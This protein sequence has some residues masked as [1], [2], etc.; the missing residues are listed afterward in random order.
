MLL[1]WGSHFSNS[2]QYSSLAQHTDA[3]IVG[4]SDRPQIHVKNKVTNSRVW[5]PDVKI[6]AKK[7]HGFPNLYIHMKCQ[8][9]KFKKNTHAKPIWV[10]EHVCNW[11]MMARHTK[12]MM[13]G[14][15]KN[16]ELSI[17]EKILRISQKIF[18]IKMHHR[19]TQTCKYSLH[20]TSAPELLIHLHHR[21]Y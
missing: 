14:P 19:V 3:P 6:C 18:D 13:S 10:Q 1:S 12:H 17:M 11:L 15:F 20:A 7:C 4:E 21:L 2:S 5:T 16:C 9:T 8:C